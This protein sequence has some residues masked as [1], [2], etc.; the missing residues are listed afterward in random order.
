[1]AQQERPPFELP[2]DLRGPLAVLRD[3]EAAELLGRAVERRFERRAM[4]LHQ[5]ERDGSVHVILDGRVGVVMG[6]P[7][8]DE[9]LVAIRGPGDL[10]GELAVFDPA[11]RLASAIALE[12]VRTLVLA[13][14]AFVDFVV[15]HPEVARTMLQLMVRR[16][17]E[18]DRRLVRSRTESTSTRLARNLLE[19][20][21]RYGRATEE[22]ILLDVPLSQEQ[23]ASLVGASRESVNGA[24]GELRRSGAI[25]TGRMR[26]VL[27]DLAQL[28]EVAL[29]TVAAH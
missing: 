16:L 21:A 10:I 7:E 5:G 12:N 4:L 24:L 6:T 9:V 20:G 8:G 29:G 27:L 1:M 28:R 14:A 15:G 25:T 26:I 23:L 3:D 18:A 11:P 17:R 13:G 22:G 19:L 2:S